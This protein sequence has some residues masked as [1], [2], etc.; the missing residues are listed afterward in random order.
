MKSQ[1]TFFYTWDCFQLSCRK[2]RLMR[3]R[4]CK[5]SWQEILLMHALWLSTVRPN[6][7]RTRDAHANWNVFPLML[8]ACSVDTPIHINR[9]HLF[10]VASY[11]LCG[12]GLKPSNWSHKDNFGQ[13]FSTFVG[14]GG[15]Q[16]I[17]ICIPNSRITR[18][19]KEIA[20][21]NANLLT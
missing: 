17:P 20:L 15:F 16:F 6:S 5:E 14:T 7:H 19:P 2:F 4:D 3:M 1:Q 8:L 12:L 21:H 11:I 13:S 10:C 9:S 18:S